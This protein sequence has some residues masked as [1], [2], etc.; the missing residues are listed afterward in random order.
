MYEEERPSQGT[1]RSGK[2]SA[3]SAEVSILG[4]ELQLGRYFGKTPATPPDLIRHDS[5][6]WLPAKTLQPHRLWTP[7]DYF[8][9]VTA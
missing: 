4:P 7:P 3:R 5:H 2:T 6:A 8:G 1:A 9:T